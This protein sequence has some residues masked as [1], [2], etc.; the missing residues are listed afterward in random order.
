MVIQELLWTDNK[1]F[2]E[3]D[4]FELNASVRFLHDDMFDRFT[5][6]YCEHDVVLELNVD[7]KLCF[8]F[9]LSSFRV[10]RVV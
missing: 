8:Q 7:E 3:R 5:N 9:K 4:S 6:A 10:D 1:N 2:Y